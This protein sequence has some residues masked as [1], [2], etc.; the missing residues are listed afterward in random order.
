M[1]R[2]TPI[3]PSTILTRSTTSRG[4]RLLAVVPGLVPPA[5]VLTQSRSAVCPLHRL[6]APLKFY[7]AEVVTPR[8]ST[9]ALPVSPNRSCTDGRSTVPPTCRSA[10][11]AHKAGNASTSNRTLS[12]VRTFTIRSG[13]V[14]MPGGGCMYGRNGTVAGTDCTA[15]PHTDIVTCH[16]GAC[17]I[18]SCQA[19][20][21]LSADGKEC[22]M[23]PSRLG[24]IKGGGRAGFAIQRRRS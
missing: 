21:M 12:H 19:G 3:S 10:R 1:F 5:T 13:Q 23:N 15:I 22:E 7:V 8:P 24:D 6:A 11:L 16:K 20:F 2:P 18:D 4:S 9:L 17:H 14:L